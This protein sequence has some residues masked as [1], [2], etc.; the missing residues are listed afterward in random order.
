[1]KIQIPHKPSVHEWYHTQ[2]LGGN[3]LGL[4]KQHDTR[5][6]PLEREYHRIH[7]G[8]KSLGGGSRYAVPSPPQEGSLH[9]FAR[10]YLL[11]WFVLPIC[12]TSLHCFPISTAMG[13]TQPE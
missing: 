2:S 13:L 4:K 9:C 12:H 6:L 11:G 1:M 7:T 8:S 3:I 10:Q 5:T